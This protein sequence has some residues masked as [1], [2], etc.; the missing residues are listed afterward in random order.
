MSN[1]PERTVARVL[2]VD[3][4]PGGEQ[5]VCYRLYDEDGIVLEKLECAV[6]DS[7]WWRA[8]QLLKPRFG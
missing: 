3:E 5:V 8:F 2:A 1:L 7:G 6:L 4:A